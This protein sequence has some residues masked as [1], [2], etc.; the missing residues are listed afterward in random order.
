MRTSTLVLSILLICIQCTTTPKPEKDINVDELTIAEAHAGFRNKIFTSEQLVQ[1]YL[2]RI[3]QKDSLINSITTVNPE[4]LRIARQLDEEYRKTNVL[5]PLHGIPVIVKDNIHTKGIIT[6]AGAFSLKDFVPAEDAFIIRKLTDAGAIVLAKSNMAEWAFTP[7]SSESSVH[8]MTLNP[9]NRKFSPAGSSGGT[10]AAIASDFGIIGLGTDT[11]NSIRGPSSHCALVGFRAT[12]GLI[13]RAGVIP[14]F[15]RNDMAGPMCRTVEDAV[16]VLQVIAGPDFEDELTRYSEGKVSSNYMQFLQRDGLQGARI[17]VLRSIGDIEQDPEITKLLDK[18]VND[19]RRLGAVVIDS[20]EIPGWVE[21]MSNQWCSEFKKDIETYL[22][23]YS[24]TDTLKT[25]QD[26][27]ND[28]TKLAF[29]AGELR[30]AL[31][32]HGRH[33]NPEIP[34]LDAYRDERRIAFRKAV[35]DHMDRLRV[36]AFIYP[37]W[38]VK[39]ALADRVFKSYEDGRGVNSSEISPHTGQPAFTVPM[40]YTSGNLPIGLEFLGRMYAEPTLI[41]LTYSYEQGTKHRIKPG[42]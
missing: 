14:L 36:D 25:L 22:G 24:K 37:S 20:V 38:N 6:S 16:R 41:K 19:L 17:G 40:G 30:S 27:I 39:P 3:E 11:G 23:R 34:C 35:E 15:L 21:V 1:S 29:T 31:V 28:G 13:S 12:M 8:G 10:A 32:N 18:A 5:R 26:I 4:A 33:Q 9:Y 2:L 42:L 7:W